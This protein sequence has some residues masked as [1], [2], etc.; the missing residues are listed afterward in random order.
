MFW[1]TVFCKSRFTFVTEHIA[2]ADVSAET[3]AQATPVGLK[4]ISMYTA[5][6]VIIKMLCILA[7]QN[8]LDLLDN[9]HLIYICD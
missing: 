6:Y 5:T 9:S 8:P 1:L 4:I 7:Q 2:I 3:Y